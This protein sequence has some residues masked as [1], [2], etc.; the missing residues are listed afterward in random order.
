LNCFVLNGLLKILTIL[1]YVVVCL[2]L[3]RWI[4]TLLQIYSLIDEKIESEDGSKVLECILIGLC[5][6]SDAQKIIEQVILKF[7][8]YNYLFFV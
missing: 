7:K 4:Y 3:I 6:K 5:V 2:Y 1:S 8:I